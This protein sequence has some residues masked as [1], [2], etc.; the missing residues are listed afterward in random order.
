MNS[1][2]QFTNINGAHNRAIFIGD[3][4]RNFVC[5]LLQL[6]TKRRGRG[7]SPFFTA[8]SRKN[9]GAGDHHAVTDQVTGL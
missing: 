1:G 9:S 5:R 4:G 2:G 8:G 6:N 3:G 7:H